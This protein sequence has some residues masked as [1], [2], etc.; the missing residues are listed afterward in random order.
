MY[1]ILSSVSPTNYIHVQRSPGITSHL[2]P[3]SDPFDKMKVGVVTFSGLLAVP[4]SVCF[5]E[6]Q[7]RCRPFSTIHRSR[8]SLGM[9]WVST[10]AQPLQR[11][12]TAFSP[13]SKYVVHPLL[14]GVSHDFSLLHLPEQHVTR[15][16]LRYLSEFHSTFV[17]H[18]V[19]FF[20]VAMSA[21]G[22]QVF[23][24][25][26]STFGNGH[27]MIDGELF[28]RSAVLTFV[29]I[30]QEHIPFVECCSFAGH[31]LGP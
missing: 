17:Q 3:P 28:L 23:P 31:H 16:L 6:W 12:A 4:S 24:C 14:R 21:C 22:D 5:L 18:F 7:V 30:S 9:V 1:H 20:P 13:M 8:P 19:P 15:G 11:F 10:T 27:H 2:R 26:S 25:G 29:P